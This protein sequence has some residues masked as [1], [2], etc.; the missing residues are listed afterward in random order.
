MRSSDWSSDV[1]SSDLSYKS[2]TESSAG[3]TGNAPST[4]T[5]T[6]VV[7]PYAG[8]IYDLSRE[9]AVYASY[10]DVFQ[11]QPNR[12]ATGSV[13]KPIRSEA[14]RVGK[15]CFSTCRSRC[16]PYP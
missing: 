10:T 15:E 5:E 8:I 7:T 2:K 3:I 11:P 1:C 6:G 9:W 16:F 4:G 12:D 13:L 14:L